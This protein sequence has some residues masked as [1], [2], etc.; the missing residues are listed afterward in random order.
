MLSL[1]PLLCS[2][3]LRVVENGVKSS[4][5]PV[6]SGVPQGSVLGSVLFNIF[7]NDLDEGIECTLS[8]FADDT[9]LGGSVDLL[10]GRKALQRDLDRLDQWAEAN[11]TRFNKAKCRVL[12]LGHNNPMQQYRLGE[13]WL[14]SCLAEKDLAVL[15]NSWLNTSRQCAQVAKKV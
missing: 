1:L 14:E 13:V 5:R 6:T 15:F 2:I 8:K 12:H 7:V 9:K 4:W 11:C 3:A 10:G